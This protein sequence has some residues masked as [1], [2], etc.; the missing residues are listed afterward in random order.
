MDTI[1]PREI[2]KELK[3]SYLDYAMSVIVSRALPDVRDGLKPVH[4]RVLWTMWETGL[5]HL[6]KYRKSANVVGATMGNYHPHGDTAIYDTLVRMA[7][8]FSLRYPLV[9]GQGNFGSVDGDGSAAMRYTES[10]LSRIA[11]E[12]LFDIEKETVDWQPNY[13]ATRKEP[14]VLPAKLPNLLLNGSV[15]IAVGMTTNIPPHN[16]GEVVDAILFLAD[17]AQATNDDLSKFIKG[18]DFPTGGVIFDENAIKAC[19]ASG[20]GGITTRAKAEIVE[21]KNNRQ[22]DIIVTEIP[23]QVNKSNLSNRLPNCIRIKRWK[24][25]GTSEMNQI[26]KG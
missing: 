7:Q 26:V 12:L 1:E 25:Y 4:R 15:G 21:K 20:R 6:A 23:Y 19:Y 14:K 13:D 22:F 10:R 2:T 24:G 17:N 5:T 11:E 3:E 18:P 9:Q 8:D 16:L